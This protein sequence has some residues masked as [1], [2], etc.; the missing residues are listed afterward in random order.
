MNFKLKAL[1]AAV[2]IVAG[3]GSANAAISTAASKD[4]SLVMFAY[5]ASSGYVTGMF[6]LG[7]TLDQVIPSANSINSAFTTGGAG[8]EIVWNFKSDTVTGSLGSSASYVGAQ[9]GSWSSEYAT[10]ISGLN[11]ASDIRYGVIAASKESAADIRALSTTS[12]N[13]K[14]A[15]QGK[16]NAAAFSTVYDNFVAPHNLVGT[17]DD[18]LNGASSSVETAANAAKANNAFGAGTNWLTKSSFNATANAGTAMS[19]FYI[20]TTN[21]GSLARTQQFANN[22]DA[23]KIATFNFNA[24]TGT[25]TYDVAAVAAAVPE[26]ESYA[27]FLAGLGMLAAFARRRTK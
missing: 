21:A 23:S 20:D 25:L 18:S 5:S 12:E 3:I 27:M 17:N 1:A 24:A 19:F 15:L 26:P 14:V 7:L 6:D 22:L 10:F 8:A 4:G 16:S 2:A 9:T 13:A 11:G